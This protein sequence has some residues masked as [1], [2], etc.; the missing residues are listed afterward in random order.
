MTSFLEESKE[1]TPSKSSGARSVVSTVSRMRGTRRRSVAPSSASVVGGMVS[2]RADVRARRAR[3]RSSSGEDFSLSEQPDRTVG[4]VS[5]A[6]SNECSVDSKSVGGGDALMRQRRA[7]LTSSNGAEIPPGFPAAAV[8]SPKGS[9][10]TSLEMDGYCSSPP[11][12]E[13]TTKIRQRQQQ[14]RASLNGGSEVPPPSTVDPEVNAFRKSRRRGSLETMK[15]VMPSSTSDEQ[16]PPPPPQPPTPLVEEKTPEGS[17]KRKSRR[18]LS[19]GDT[20]YEAVKTPPPPPP[21]PNPE[22]SFNRKPRRRSGIGGTGEAIDAP[23]PP[24]EEKTPETSSSRKQSGRLG[25][26]GT[27]DESKASTDPKPRRK[28]S[29]RRNTHVSS[30]ASCVPD[31]AA[32]PPKEDKPTILGSLESR[33][34]NISNSKGSKKASKRSSGRSVASMPAMLRKDSSSKKGSS[35]KGKRPKD[36]LPKKPSSK[37]RFTCFSEIADFS[38][39]EQSPPQN[40]PAGHVNAIMNA[41]MLSLDP[42]LLKKPEP[43]RR[44]SS[45]AELYQEGE[46][47][48]MDLNDPSIPGSIGAPCPGTPTK[49]NQSTVSLDLV[50]VQQVSLAFG[51]TTG[52]ESL[53][54]YS[55]AYSDSDV[56]RSP[57]CLRRKI[58]QATAE[59]PK[60]DKRVTWV[61]LPLHNPETLLVKSADRDG[62]NETSTTTTFDAAAISTSDDASDDEREETSAAAL[63]KPKKQE[64]VTRLSSSA[65][66]QSY[67]SKPNSI[68]SLDLTLGRTEKR[69]RS[70]SEDE[71]T[72]ATT[73]TTNTANTDSSVATMKTTN[74][75]ATDRQLTASIALSG[76]PAGGDCKYQDS[77]TTDDLAE[78][79]PAGSSSS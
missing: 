70:R 77:M 72:V 78:H 49:Y 22:T 71:G 36:L 47:G 18:R 6:S 4:R 31:P 24:V 64:R 3:S 60:N 17:S 37:N 42:R 15:S 35:S 74:R 27:D 7:S 65:K 45:I 43:A 28:S 39:E 5:S 29:S 9:A 68:P 66:S 40:G 73:T 30:S 79:A 53:S 16:A 11:M 62:T 41:S 34:G 61:E 23:P 76:E 51:G 26:G 63:Y 46:E 1:G 10:A 38:S 25:I 33:L 20:T 67:K 2:S 75:S 52:R 55:S 12:L 21:P 59:S 13:S 69:R 50:Q 57:S 32:P 48:E 54:P 56:S 8:N 44:V 14:R 58:G 19:N